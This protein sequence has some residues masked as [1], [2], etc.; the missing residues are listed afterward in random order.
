MSDVKAT[1]KVAMFEWPAESEVRHHASL[2]LKIEGYDT[3]DWDVENKARTLAE[4]FGVPITVR[5][6]LTFTVPATSKD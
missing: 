3:L 6:T 4:V 2:P 5:V 1:A